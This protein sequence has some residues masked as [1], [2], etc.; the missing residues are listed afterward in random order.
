MYA[1]NKLLRPALLHRHRN[2]GGTYIYV[3][4]LETATLTPYEQLPMK[5]S[6]SP[7]PK[8]ITEPQYVELCKACNQILQAQDF[9]A[10]RVAI[11]WLH[12][13]REHPPRAF[14]RVEVKT[15]FHS[16]CDIY[17]RPSTAPTFLPPHRPADVLSSL[18]PVILSFWRKVV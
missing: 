7:E 18:P 4:T 1:I 14:K 13:I 9:T 3:P 6:P 2:N 10:E 12:V 17:P 5:M 8:F 16:C 11:S 15:S